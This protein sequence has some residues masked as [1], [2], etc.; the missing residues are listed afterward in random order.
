MSIII[1]VTI[2]F[3]VSASLPVS[4]ATVCADVF[5]DCVD[6][7]PDLCNITIVKAAC[8][9][10]CEWNST[11][12]TET[13]QV[14][15]FLGPI[16]FAGYGI[17]LLLTVIIL[18]LTYSVCLDSKPEKN[19]LERFL[20]P[21]KRNLDS[22]AVK[23]LREGDP[24]IIV[25]NPNKINVIRSKPNAF[26]DRSKPNALR[27][28]PKP[29]A[30]SDLLYSSSKSRDSFD[31]EEKRAAES[32]RSYNIVNEA[33][34]AEGYFDQ[35]DDFFKHHA[36]HRADT[37][38]FGPIKSGTLSPKAQIKADR[39]NALDASIKS[40]I[41]NSPGS[42]SQHLAASIVNSKSLTPKVLQELNQRLAIKFSVDS[43]S[44]SPAIQPGTASGSKKMYGEPSGTLSPLGASSMEEDELV[45]KDDASAEELSKKNYLRE[46]AGSI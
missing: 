20:P 3:L 42:I 4:N 23:P 36:L 22:I 7:D 31:S 5:S 21:T 29:N 9:E 39:W 2:Y 43:S 26:R 13:C 25:L 46:T 15:D 30:L 12:C 14:F 37:S 18:V 40:S 28:R 6:L 8:P 34:E 33:N 24:E 41:A 10:T 27:D 11:A 44:F 45:L 38:E 19:S 35:D 17:L 32:K 16:A 1:P